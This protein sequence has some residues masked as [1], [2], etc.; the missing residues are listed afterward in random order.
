[1]PRDTIHI[2]L[3][4]SQL[5]NIEACYEDL[6]RQAKDRGDAHLV[7]TTGRILDSVKKAL[8]LLDSPVNISHAPPYGLSAESIV[9]KWAGIFNPPPRDKWEYTLVKRATLE[10]TPEV[11]YQ[12]GNEGWELITLHYEHAYFKRR[13]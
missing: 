4:A 8:Y 12:M 3:T 6:Y 11:L 1:M 13:K 9:K 2:Q 10:K 5:R 7:A